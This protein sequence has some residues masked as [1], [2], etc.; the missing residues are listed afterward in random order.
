MKI[1]S[2]L[3]LLLIG[4]NGSGQNYTSYFTGNTTDLMTTPIGG[5]CMMGG[6][7]EHDEAMKWFLN[8]ASGGDVLV[9]RASGSDGYNDYF[10]SQLGISINSVETIVFN[11]ASASDETY[12]HQKIINAEAIWFAGG[13]QWDYISYW[14]NT[15][16][17]SLINDGL[18]N[19]NIAMGGT[20]AG[21]AILGKYY[22]SAENATVT[23]AQ[24]LANPYNFDATIDS[25][26]FLKNEFL[27]NV[28][29][30]THYD[31]PDR[32][33]RHVAFMARMITD[34]GVQNARAI[35]C[36][37]YTAVCID[38]N[39]EARVY[40]DYP[41]YDENAYFIQANC[42]VSDIEMEVC[43]PGVPLTW[44]KGEIAIKTYKIHG[45]NSG[46]NTFNL[47]TWLEG[48]GGEW[49]NWYV[50]NGV[51]NETIGQAP[52][53]VNSIVENKNRLNIYPNPT[54]GVLNF[55][56]D[57]FLNLCVNVFN[58]QGQLVYS[59]NLVKDCS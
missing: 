8:R 58:S 37:E 10:Y 22:F 50:E 27:E 32:K 38:E 33:G 53:C 41:S 9:L 29:T 36:D 40:G 16:I 18:L 43:Q 52:V 17:D 15:K 2:T 47:N 19:R 48:T 44:N 45:T 59:K 6:A 3:L 46:V 55:Q 57:N 25:T 26:V 5:I 56:S 28:I 24:M 35:A 34:F 31:N 14:R 12:I 42:E 4:L 21:M 20:S 30:D 54:N 51:L 39:G 1:I 13:D 49:Q 7:S 23:S 11:D